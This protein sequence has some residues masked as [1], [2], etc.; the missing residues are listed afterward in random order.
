[1]RLFEKIVVG[2]VYKLNKIPIL[3]QDSFD[4]RGVPSVSDLIEME[5][6]ALRGD[7]STRL[8]HIPPKKNR[9]P[10]VQPWKCWANLATHAT[11]DAMSVG[12][13]AARLA[14][15][16][17]GN[18][19]DVSTFEHVRSIVDDVIEKFGRPVIMSACDYLDF[20]SDQYE[21]L[22]NEDAVASGVRSAT[23]SIV[24]AL[25]TVV[26]PG[27][28]LLR[29][30]GV[31]LDPKLNDLTTS[32]CVT[33]T[34]S[35]L[36]DEEMPDLASNSSHYKTD[37]S[38]ENERCQPAAELREEE[39]EEVVEAFAVSSVER[40]LEEEEI[41]KSYIE[42]ALY[43][44]VRSALDSESG[45]H[46]GLA[47]GGEACMWSESV[48][49]SNFEC[50][51]WPRA[52][53]VASRLWGGSSN[54]LS[55]LC[56]G[57]PNNPLETLPQLISKYRSYIAS[58]ELGVAAEEYRKNRPNADK[59]DRMLT[60]EDFVLECTSFCD[61]ILEAEAETASSKNH[62]GESE[63]NV[64]DP[65]PS[66]SLVLYEKFGG[67]FVKNSV[68]GAQLPQSRY[69]EGRQTELSKQMMMAYAHFRF[70]LTNRLK[71]SAAG[72]T[73]HSS[74]VKMSSRGT[75]NPRMA[76]SS[77]AKH[78][79]V[80]VSSWGS[81]AVQSEDLLLRRIHRTDH[82]ISLLQQ[83]SGSSNLVYVTSSAQSPCIEGADTA[84]VCEAKSVELLRL[85]A[86][87]PGISKNMQREIPSGD[88]A[89]TATATP[90][91]LK[92]LQ[93]N[94]ENGSRGEKLDVMLE[95]LKKMA[96]ETVTTLSRSTSSR[97]RS[98][99]LVVA[100]FCELND[101]S[102]SVVISVLLL[103]ALFTVVRF[104]CI[105]LCY[106]QLR[107]RPQCPKTTH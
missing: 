102:V 22:T 18:S 28:R 62:V 104:V 76:G 105:L 77:S 79:P 64:N 66:G 86:Q 3:W 93:F 92:I 60:F 39:A 100:G 78:R 10:V 51:V 29:A 4:S 59:I 99:A 103:F 65:N 16:E 91:S 43:G 41:L 107:A 96:N 70:Y 55:L 97:P 47:Y 67:V 9:Q 85:T 14:E 20:D 38:V 15:Y 45:R 48:D 37:C 89:I 50:R 84:T 27:K 88:G 52:A 32:E 81:E 26:H 54:Q 80:A 19:A 87:C 71:I 13:D 57:S 8:S 17:Q 11:A 83:R 42:D 36:E 25:R 6:N 53:V 5:Q 24:Q 74:T 7:K 44:R 30:E 34:A 56:K 58:H 68:P 1:V 94:T 46:S 31:V 90:H 98:E 95:W 23:R 49:F 72:M 69:G 63:E 61:D 82:T 35:L 2:E 101:W 75:T 106:R 12:F 21:L 33:D 40:R 73:L